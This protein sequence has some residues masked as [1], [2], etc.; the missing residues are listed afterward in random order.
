MGLKESPA[1]LRSTVW[2]ATSFETK[3][4]ALAVLVGLADWRRWESHGSDARQFTIDSVTSVV[5]LLAIYALIG[6]P[7]WLTP[8][9]PLCTFH[10]WTVLVFAAIKLLGLV[11]MRAFGDCG[12]TLMVVLAL[13]GV[14]IAPLLYG[15]PLLPDAK[16]GSGLSVWLEDFHYVG[17][18]HLFVTLFFYVLGFVAMPKALEIL[19]RPCLLGKTSGGIFASVQNLPRAL[20]SCLDAIRYH[21]KFLSLCIALCAAQ[22]F[23]TRVDVAYDPVPDLDWPNYFTTVWYLP[24]LVFDIFLCALLIAAAWE[25]SFV[26]SA[27]G[28][29]GQS[30]FGTYLIHLYVHPDLNAALLYLGRSFRAPWVSVLQLCLIAFAPAAYILTVGYLVQM[31][32]VALVTTSAAAW[33]K[34]ASCILETAARCPRRRR[35]L[36]VHDVI[37]L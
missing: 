24:R 11:C 35:E 12:G 31:A 1:W 16:M 13:V 14:S 19:R 33:R 9:L 30:L 2:V 34:L 6:L 36:V 37:E 20:S 4:H 21:L 3:M 15:L 8:E 23:L 22:V 10:R 26:S 7:R 29:V 32:V 28:L 27:L 5:M 25:S 17:L 18:A